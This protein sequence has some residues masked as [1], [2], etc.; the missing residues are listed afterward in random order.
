MLRVTDKYIQ[1]TFLDNLT[2]S[3]KSLNDIQTKMASH[4]Q[5]Q[6][7]SDSPLG[8]ARINRLQNQI[9][10]ITNYQDNIEN[11]KNFLVTTSNT[12]ETMESNI[13]SIL[14]DLSTA[15]SATNA[16]N[17]SQFSQ[18]IDT[19]IKSILQLANTEV[20]GKYLFAG[21]STDT[22]PFTEGSYYAVTDN[23]GGEQKIKISANTEQ[24][25]NMTG[26]EVFFP[27]IQ[28]TGSMDKNAAVGTTIQN[29]ATVTDPSGN[30]FN[31]IVAYTKTAAGQYTMQYDV[32]D[33]NNVSVGSGS[34]TL[35]FDN[36]GALQSVNGGQVSKFAVDIPGSKV[37]FVLDPT[38]LSEGA[39]G[40]VTGV[41][42]QKTNILNV[43]QSV[44]EQLASGKLPSDAQVKLIQDFDKYLLNKTSEAGGIQNRIESMSDMMST[45]Q[46]DL[47][48][49]LSKESDVD[50][51]KAI[52]EMQSAQYST[53]VM[54][55]TSAMLLPKSLLDYL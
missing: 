26:E 44:K 41:V 54:Y 8:T 21:T 25:I 3:R 45:Q 10:D 36:A 22:K 14:T 33:P 48:Q 9:S 35:A 2:K 29:I 38:Q 7:P 40:S 24:K 19:S 37:G 4:Q 11:G 15:N 5:V 46:V 32:R 34:K 13:Q 52:I 23:L 20:D 16:S 31:V 18:K 30:N 6:K 55:K 27:V 47:Q 43:L 51:A 50:M 49:L 17:L 1:Q 53:D 39:S 28:E 12:M 42:S